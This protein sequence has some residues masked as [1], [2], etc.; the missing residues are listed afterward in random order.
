VFAGGNVEVKDTLRTQFIEVER[1]AI[2]DTLVVGRIMSKDSLIYLGDST[3]VINT[4]LR[5]IYNDEAGGIKGVGIGKGSWGIGGTYA[6][7]ANSVAIGNNVRTTSI[8]TNSAII[9]SSSSG[10]SFF[11]N[12]KPNSLMV[13]FKSN[14]PTLYVGPSNGV[15]TIGNVGIGTTNPQALLHVQNTSGDT[16]MI[17]GTNSIDKATYWVGN[18]YFGYGFGI[19]ENAKGH[20]YYNSN[21][22]PLTSCMTFAM[23]GKIGIHNDD[24]QYE[25][26]VCGEIKA[27]KVR[28]TLQGC[29]FVF[30]NDYQLMPLAELEQYLIKNRHLPGV[31]SAKEM[32]TEEGVE[33]GEMQSKLLQKIEELTLYIIEQNKRIDELEKKEKH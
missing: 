19:D 24:P 33:I 10:S 9:G 31:T 22:N 27:Q 28:V 20:I 4:S 5:K 23:N 17:L 16:K 6:I 21:A 12:D 8:A 2:F 7:G 15:N 32:E 26:D 30:E 18:Y 13:G 3:L 25:L 14:I 1:R 11:L 29:D